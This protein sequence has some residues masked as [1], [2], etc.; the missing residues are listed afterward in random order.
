M[1]GHSKWSTIKHAKAITDA[2]RGKLF[3]KLAR[4]IIIAAGQGGADTGMNIRLRMAIQ[5]GRDANMPND[6]IERAI[7]RGTGEGGDADQMAEFTYEGYGPGGTAILLETL[8]DNKNRTVSDVRAT[9]TKA[10]GNLAQSGAVA[11][12]FQQKGVVVVNADEAAAEEYTLV[13]I[14]AGAEDFDTFDSTLQIFSPPELMEDIR[15][16]L[17]EKD[18]S[19][20][21]SELSMIPTSTISLDKKTALQTLRLLDLLEDLDDVQ[22]VYSNADFPDDALEQYQEEE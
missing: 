5:K 16:T 20:V 6:N 3:T 18:A 4:E 7:K 22:K 9:L 8:S 17:S 13:A 10:G 2:R 1:S 21:S 15:N 11:W 12:Q 19:I 14:D